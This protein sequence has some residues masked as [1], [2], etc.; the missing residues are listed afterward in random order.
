MFNVVP[1][2]YNGKKKKKK[3][4]SVMT[5]H[6]VASERTNSAEH[7]V[8]CGLSRGAQPQPP[9]SDFTKWPLFADS[10]S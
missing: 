1:I 4:N 5:Q 8:S 3:R 6:F 2:D 7:R 10:N 9:G